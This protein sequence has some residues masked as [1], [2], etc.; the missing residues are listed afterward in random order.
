V[1]VQDVTASSDGEAFH[2]GPAVLD[3]QH[4]LHQTF[5]D[6]E[7]ERDILALFRD[8]CGKLVPVILGNCQLP[9]RVDAAHTLKGGAR[10][11]GAVEVARIA[12]EVESALRHHG[13]LAGGQCEALSAS[14]VE[15]RQAID[16]R[17]TSGKECAGR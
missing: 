12:D 5:G 14:I 1:K 17:L 2:L 6:A 3:I 15:I 11:I 9:S 10:A 16:A 4:L 13:E 8:Q 7:L